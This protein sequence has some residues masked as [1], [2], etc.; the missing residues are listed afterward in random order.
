MGPGVE[1]FALRDGKDIQI[2]HLPGA[3]FSAGFEGN[4]NG[5]GT[6]RRR[7]TSLNSPVFLVFWP[8]LKGFYPAV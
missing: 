7:F 1:C 4:M 6:G 8:A 5:E 2:W 3:P